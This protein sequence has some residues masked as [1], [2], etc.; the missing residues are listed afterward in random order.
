[1]GKMTMCVKNGG[2]IEINC[3]YHAQ[4]LC[5]KSVATCGLFQFSFSFR[6]LV[7]LA[8]LNACILVTNVQ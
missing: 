5:G 1:M 6:L 2:S 8:D 3:N 4:G 7:L